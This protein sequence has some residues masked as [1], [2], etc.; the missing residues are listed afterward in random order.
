MLSARH[1]CRALVAV[2]SSALVFSAGSYASAVPRSHD[3][4]STPTPA[5]ARAGVAPEN[6]YMG[7]R[8]R[9]ETTPPTRQTR[10]TTIT[11]AATSTSVQGIDVASYQGNVNW[12]YWWSQGKRFAYVK[13][14]EGTSYRNPY[15]SSQY[16]GSYNIGMIRGAYHFARPANSSGIAQADYFVRYGGSWSRDGRTL[17]GVLDIEYNPYGAT[18]Y[19]LTQVQIVSWIKAFTTRYKQRTGRD[20]VIYSTYDWWSRC[21]GNS[22][23][24]NR[25]N[26]LWIARYS[27]SPGTLPGGWLYYTFWQ[28]TSTPID[29]DRFSGSYTR[30]KALALG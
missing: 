18:C 13:A 29:Q 20:A 10:Q 16:R 7:W 19:G 3:S 30:L 14:T 5:A 15:F 28:Y 6:A 27:T 2:L 9:T 24:F 12:S 22:T 8:N 26:P 21:T 4:P 25:T 17:P 11:T 1:R 23:A